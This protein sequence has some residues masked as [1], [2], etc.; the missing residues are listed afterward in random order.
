M[1]IGLITGEY[2]PLH[3]GVGDF[4][5]EVAREL[6][7]A[8][9]TVHVLTTHTHDTTGTSHEDGITVH[10]TVRNWGWQTRADVLKWAHA[11]KIELLNLQYQAAA[12]HMH[13]AINL[14]P[15][16]LGRHL[17]CVVTFHDLRVPYLFAKAGK[18]RKA[19][20]YHMAR[21]ASGIIVTNSEDG[22]ELR[23]QG[24]ASSL[25]PIGSNIVPQPPT[26]HDPIAW[27][28]ARNIPEDMRLFGYFGFMNESK[29]GI[30]L[31]Q[32]L[33]QI[34]AKTKISLLFIGEQLGASDP[35]NADYRTALKGLIASQ[36]LQPRVFE[37]GYL[38]AAGVSET[39]AMC[40]C[41]AL[42]YSDG[43]SYRRGTLMA[44]LAH[45]C[46]LVT[47]DPSAPTPAIVDGE[48]MLLVPPGN[49]S[50]LAGAV[51]RVFADHP[52][53][54]RLQAGAKDLSKLF[55]WDSIAAETLRVFKSVVAN[56]R[57]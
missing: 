7:R 34:P 47:T 55:T 49:P 26:F 32:A 51:M 38:D 13:G 1:H 45:G 44:A 3:G 42:P 54:I 48:N 28:R 29:G 5:R 56:R 2:P 15:G 43:V 10:R 46:A 6:A 8:G 37:T 19:V 27:R 31:L 12:Y 40:D 20:M 21:Q 23:S 52:L 24:I 39:F 14:L 11:N 35:T 25:I 17:P 30:N 16:Q 57:G 4:T 18:L 41:L 33:E 50:A 22:D 53:R 9:H 36:G